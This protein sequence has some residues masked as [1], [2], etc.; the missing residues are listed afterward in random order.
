MNMHHIRVTY[1]RLAPLIA[2]VAVLLGCTAAE[3]RTQVTADPATGNIAVTTRRYR[4]RFEGGT[5]VYLHNRLMDR[6]LVDAAADPDLPTAFR[7]ALYV[8][9]E[10]R[11][12]PYWIAPATGGERRST[13]RVAQATPRG[14]AVTFT[15]LAHNQRFFPDAT[16][17]LAVEI[18]PN[19]RT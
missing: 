11:A 3:A 1:K 15:G 19:G 4:A 18:A 2:G 17:T 16:L 10:P 13:V 5:L 6:T 7:T 12:E 14:I 9:D 8:S